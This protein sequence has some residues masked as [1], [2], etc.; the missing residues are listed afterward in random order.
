MTSHY[1]ETLQRDTEVIRRKVLEMAGL[2]QRALQDSLRAILERNRQFAYAVILRDPRIDELEKQLDRLCLEFL[3]RQQPVAGHLRFAYAAIKINAE[4]ERIGDYAESIVRQTLKLEGIGFE[5]PAERLR[6]I[7]E[8]SIPMLGEAVRS[9]LTQNAELARATMA[10]EEQV[11]TLRKQIDGELVRAG[12]AGQIPIEALVPLM[13]IVRRFERVSDQA[14]NICEEALYMCTGEYSKHRGTEAIRI[15]FVDEHNGCRSLMAEAIAQALGLPGFIFNSAGLDP[16]PADAWTLEFLKEKGID[17]SRQAPRTM[18]QVPNL[19]YY[20]VIIALD[21]EGL[22][23][24]PPPP[25]K[26]VC[27]EWAVRDPSALEGSPAEISAAYEEA[28]QIIQSQIK[29]LTE[30]IAGTNNE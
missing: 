9:F 2:V 24:F 16:R 26:T 6:E 13:T 4:L 11:D 5:V 14:K 3:V 27:L 23:A 22:K 28:Y 1:E 18:D 29:D 19:E 15:L 8:L 17:R 7:A 25:T 20:Q 21:K 10:V 30:A 12:Q